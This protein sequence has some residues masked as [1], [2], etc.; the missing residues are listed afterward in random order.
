[1]AD[2]EQ[3]PEMQRLA[4]E[5]ALKTGRYDVFAKKDIPAST[6]PGYRG[7]HKNPGGGYPQKS[8]GTIAETRKGT[9]TNRADPGKGNAFPRAEPRSPP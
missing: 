4:P 7:G 3:G 2:Y 8:T 5:S 1:M 6:E 9:K